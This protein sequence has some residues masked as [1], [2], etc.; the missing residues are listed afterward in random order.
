MRGQRLTR[1]ADECSNCLELISDYMMIFRTKDAFNAASGV[2]GT[3][4]DASK[5][6]PTAFSS[7]ARARYT[8]Y[9]DE[10]LGEAVANPVAA[11]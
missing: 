2:L 1:H 5:D 3:G 4:Q 7:G 8:L 11:H 9:H 10:V 6:E